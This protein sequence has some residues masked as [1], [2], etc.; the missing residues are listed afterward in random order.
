MPGS[1]PTGSRVATGVTRSGP[2]IAIPTPIARRRRS[3]VANRR[4]RTVAWSTAPTVILPSVAARDRCHARRS[5]PGYPRGPRTNRHSFRRPVPRV[6]TRWI[7]NVAPKPKEDESMAP[8]V[9]VLVGAGVLALL[10]LLFRGGA[11]GRRS[12]VRRPRRRR[13]W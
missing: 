5:A 7:A 12:I 3:G 2:T 9:W 13:V 11:G 6:A 4:S 10:L 1:S 8:W